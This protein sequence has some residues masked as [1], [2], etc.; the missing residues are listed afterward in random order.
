MADAAGV[1]VDVS[2]ANKEDLKSAATGYAYG[3][4]GAFDMSGPSSN[5][6]GNQLAKLA[7]VAGVAIVAG[8]AIAKRKG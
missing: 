4:T 3:A 6:S 5:E 2:V 7:L 8:M 1:K